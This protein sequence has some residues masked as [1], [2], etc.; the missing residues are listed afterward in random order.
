MIIINIKDVKKKGENG[1]R[2]LDIPLHLLVIGFSVFI[3]FIYFFFSK[4]R[5]LDAEEIKSVENSQENGFSISVIIPA[6]NEESNIGKILS[7]LNLQTVKP[8]EVIVVDD[9]SIDRTAKIVKAFQNDNESIKL[10]SL[11]EEPPEGWV[12]KSWAIWNG[13][14]HSSG[15]ILIFMDADVEP[16][17]KTLEALVS[18]YRRYG[19]LIS[20]WPY[21]RFEKFY[22]HLNLVFNL[23][24]TYAGNM[25]GFPSEKPV[26]AFGPV[27]LT[28]RKD[29][30]KTGG[31][32]TI[33]DSVLEDIK[34]GKLYVESG[35]RVTNLL[36]KSV[37]KFRM[38]PNGFRQLFDGFSKNMSSG[39]ISNGLLN[40]LIALIW[41]SGFYSSFASFNM[42]LG[43]VVLRYAGFTIIVYLL[44][45]PIGD[46]KW[47]DAII[48]PLHF[49][50]FAVVFLYSLYKTTIL[51]KVT[52]RGREIKFK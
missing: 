32:V 28:S 27:I 38:Y 23:V 10:I 9:N 5:Y 24:V 7:L 17:E 44:S 20:V 19:G 36:G 33:K 30:E 34:L 47:Y 8:Y 22:E 6:R 14:K 26:G 41:L 48:Y 45:K 15:N 39:A 42:P 50:F 2:F 35:I 37:V 40:F 43:Y 11:K 51:K 1:L 46:Y 4:R 31:H 25:L 21:Q 29:Y 12:G 3:S 16:G 49:I 18:N 52:W 13:Y